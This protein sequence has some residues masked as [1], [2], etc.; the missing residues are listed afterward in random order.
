MRS[1]RRS[2]G[3]VSV[4]RSKPGTQCRGHTKVE[5]TTKGSRIFVG[6]NYPGEVSKDTLHKKHDVSLEPSSQKL[7]KPHQFR[8]KKRAPTPSNGR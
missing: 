3:M 1:G 5:G 8:Y 7:I 6:G 4:L 2:K